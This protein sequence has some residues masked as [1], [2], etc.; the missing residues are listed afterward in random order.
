MSNSEKRTVVITGASSGIGLELA[1]LFAAGGYDLI[2]TAR[3]VER[4][5][6]LAGELCKAHGIEVHTIQMD[7]AQ[8]LAGAELWKAITDI[9]SDVEV[10]VN[11]AGVGDSG[12]FANES[13]EKIGRMIYLNISSMTLLTRYV[14]PV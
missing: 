3:R 8:P 1:R 12:D 2:V 10:L 11:N 4:L 9:T 13:P 14:C 7:I 5:E 6:Q